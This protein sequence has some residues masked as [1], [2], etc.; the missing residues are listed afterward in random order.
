ML[1][2]VHLGQ[3]QRVGQAARG[4]HVPQVLLAEAALHAVD[5]HRA[6]L[7]GETDAARVKH[8]ADRLARLL[9]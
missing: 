2:R 9:L 8:L 5:A 3:V 6:V 4:Q 7:A 1:D